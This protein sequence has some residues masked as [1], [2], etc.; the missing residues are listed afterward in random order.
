M[1]QAFNLIQLPKAS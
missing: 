1:C